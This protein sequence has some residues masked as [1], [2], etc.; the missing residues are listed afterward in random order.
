MDEKK[1][2]IE[3]YCLT[4]KCPYYKP[5]HYMISMKHNFSYMNAFIINHSV[6]RK[7]KQTRHTYTH[8]DFVH[9]MSNIKK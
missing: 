3:Y 9:Q 6:K 4:R 1:Y 2:T 7:V 5:F 8:T